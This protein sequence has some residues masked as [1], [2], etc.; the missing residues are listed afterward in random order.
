MAD[1]I[2]IRRDTTANWASSNPVLA[3]GELGYDIDLNKW[4]VGNSTS[5]WS[6]LT[7][8]NVIGETGAQG[9]TG[10]QGSQGVTGLIGYTG[11]QGATGLDG[12]YV[13]QGYTGIQG[14]T[15]LGIEIPAPI[16][17]ISN[18]D[19][20]IQ[21]YNNTEVNYVGVTGMS[22][23]VKAGK[24]YSFDCRLSFY[25]VYLGRNGLPERD[26]YEL[27]LGFTGA[28]YDDDSMC[29]CAEKGPTVYS[30]PDTLSYSYD[31]YNN[32]NNKGSNNIFYGF[33][34]YLYGITLKG[35]FPNVVSDD[36]IVM[37]L[38][39]LPRDYENVDFNVKNGS[40]IN[41]TEY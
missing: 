23:N 27:Y 28:Q 21:G 35:S 14:V 9:Y 36:T 40:F 32:N 6:S 41:V 4:K 5:N 18:T 25:D 24:S 15:G 12:G 17:K 16:G 8:V 31:S 22:I 26:Y 13:S 11:S 33:D 2:Q 1:I 3:Q 37:L 29:I 10:L 19:I 20:P 39:F 30:V 34:N 38:G 7:F